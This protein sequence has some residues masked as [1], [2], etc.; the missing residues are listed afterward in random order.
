MKRLLLTIS[1]S[2]IVLTTIGAIY[3]HC[4]E[5]KHHI[6]ID[7]QQYPISGIDISA[8]NGD[9]D[10]IKIAQSGI[11]FVFIKA[12][13]GATFKDPRFHSNYNKA[14]K[15]GLK[16]GAYHF[17]R[18]NTDGYLQALNILHSLKGKHLDLPIAIDIE[19]YTNDRNTPTEYIISQIST[20]INTFKNNNLPFIFYTNKNGYTRFIKGNFDEYPLWICSFSNPPISEKWQFWQYS[21]KGTI[22]GVFGNIDLNTYNGTN[23]DWNKWL[24]SI[25][26]QSQ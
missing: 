12:T 2:I 25:R 16:V 11:D 10:F 9:I 23:E 4:L 7:S 21:H 18:F 22:K 6:D 26:Y 24:N 13:E 19:E 20:L 17:F 3:W 15:S 8:H 1:L 5:R 14:L